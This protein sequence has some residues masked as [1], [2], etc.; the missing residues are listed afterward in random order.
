MN[1]TQRKAIAKQFERLQKVYGFTIVDGDQPPNEVNQRLR[2]GIE[3][4][5]A[6][7]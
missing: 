2:A 6:G 5:L 7:K 1:A 4:V 3:H